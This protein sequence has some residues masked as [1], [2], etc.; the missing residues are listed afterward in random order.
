MHCN[1]RYH[2]ASCIS[3][4]SDNSSTKSCSG[5]VT[6]PDPHHVC[7]AVWSDDTADV[8]SPEKLM[9]CMSN[10]HDD[11]REH[12]GECV[13]KTGPKSGH[14]FCCCIGNLCNQK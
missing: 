3:R 4:A 1:F 9:G 14:H 5:T 7:Y 10:T 11:C 13:G 8:S 2:D 12:H 6:C